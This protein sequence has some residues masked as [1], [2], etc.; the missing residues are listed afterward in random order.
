MLAA[1]LMRQAAKSYYG[2][3]CSY[4]AISRIDSPSM[5]AIRAVRF[6][7][8]RTKPGYPLTTHGHATAGQDP[9]GRRQDAARR[10]QPRDEGVLSGAVDVRSDLLRR[11]RASSPP[12]TGH[13]GVRAGVGAPPA[14]H[15]GLHVPRAPRRGDL[16]VQGMLPSGFFRRNVVLSFQEDAVGIRLRDVIGPTT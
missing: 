13:R 14:L 6:L 4:R 12:H 3:R 10:Q 5:R 1:S 15:H 7:D 16:P 9:R 8:F 2:R 11:L